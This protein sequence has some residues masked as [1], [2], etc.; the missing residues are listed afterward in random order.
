M[1]PT[2]TRANKCP[3]YV[4]FRMEKL[5][6]HRAVIVRHKAHHE[7][8]SLTSP[9]E[10][11]VAAVNDELVNFIISQ[12]QLVSYFPCELNDKFVSIVSKNLLKYSIIML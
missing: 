6:R 10:K 2:E 8:H 7:G 4:S 1:G 11:H 3:S 9:N 12:L 5:Q